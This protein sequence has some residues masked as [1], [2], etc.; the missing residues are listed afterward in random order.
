[1]L[2]SLKKR[3]VAAYEKCNNINTFKW[4]IAH[5]INSSRADSDQLAHMMKGKPLFPSSSVH[6][7]ILKPAV[8]I[9]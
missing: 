7:L 4:Q 6:Q 1:M 2:V 9:Y 8:N 5:Q 3:K